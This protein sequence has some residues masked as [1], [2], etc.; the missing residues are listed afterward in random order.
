MKYDHPANWS[1]N[2]GMSSLR[3]V[4]PVSQSEYILVLVFSF[5][6]FGYGIW[7]GWICLYKTDMVINEARV[8]WSKV[9][10]KLRK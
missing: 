2:L 7:M 1:S 5:I 10:E 6:V 9:T 8:V 4:G 3:L